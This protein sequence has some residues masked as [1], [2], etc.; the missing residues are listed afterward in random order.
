MIVC[1]VCEY[2]VVVF[3]LINRHRKLVDVLKMSHLSFEIFFLCVDSKSII[4]NLVRFDRKF[5]WSVIDCYDGRLK[6]V[7]KIYHLDR[8]PRWIGF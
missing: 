3:Q 2:V 8:V 7:G 4:V 5:V 1:V 6:C